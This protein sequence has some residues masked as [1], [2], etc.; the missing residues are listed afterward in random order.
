MDDRLGRI[1]HCA[2][3][4]QRGY[5]MTI[6]SSHDETWIQDDRIQ[7]RTNERALILSIMAMIAMSL[8]IMWW[9]HG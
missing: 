1:V 9:F 2:E 6:Q 7:D 5:P 3:R 8:L 4:V